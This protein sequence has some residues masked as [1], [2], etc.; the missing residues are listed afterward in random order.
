VRAT[1]LLAYYDHD[2]VKQ[3]LLAPA[4]IPVTSLVRERAAEA[5]EARV[6]EG[7]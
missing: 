4:T 5:V 1:A 7:S 2:A 3:A 6:A